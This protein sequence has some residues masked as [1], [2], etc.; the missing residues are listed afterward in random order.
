[1]DT[2]VPRGGWR[3]LGEVVA[4]QGCFEWERSSSGAVNMEHLRVGD[5][6]TIQVV[7]NSPDPAFEVQ[8][9]FLGTGYTATGD[10]YGHALYAALC[11]LP[12][13]WL[14][15]AVTPYDIG[16]HW[17]SHCGFLDLMPPLPDLPG[18]PAE[19]AAGTAP[20]RG[21]GSY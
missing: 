20:D 16:I 1:M 7:N 3:D 11:Q 12:D 8:H 9:E 4:A 19:A 2:E 14:P 10:T 15:A 17:D 18:V 13:A 6:L 21:S 5:H